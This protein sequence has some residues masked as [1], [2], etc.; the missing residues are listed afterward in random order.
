MR[1]IILSAS[2]DGLGYVMLSILITIAFLF[3]AR[4]IFGMGKVIDNLQAHTD[5]LR[6]MRKVMYKV[7]E[8]SGVSPKEI[9]DMEEEVRIQNNNN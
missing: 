3:L 2:D 7:A 1:Y 8:K 5:N 9:E 4:W 6:V